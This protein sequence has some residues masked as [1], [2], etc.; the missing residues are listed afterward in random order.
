MDINLMWRRIWVC[1]CLHI[2]ISVWHTQLDI[3]LHTYT[4]RLICINIYIYIHT[5][6]CTSNE[7]TAMWF[8]PF[9]CYGSGVMKP[10]GW[11]KDVASA[12][13]NLHFHHRLS[14]EVIAACSAS[15]ACRQVASPDAISIVR[16]TFT[17][18]GACH[19]TD[20]HIRTPGA[21]CPFPPMAILQ[22]FNGWKP[23]HTCQ[24]RYPS[25]WL[26][27]WWSPLQYCTIIL[28]CPHSKLWL[29]CLEYG[30][31]AWCNQCNVKFV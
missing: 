9:L 27:M 4:H 19:A 24:Q 7:R 21:H 26:F 15:S 5:Y 28:E 23:Y 10:D 8:P 31:L 20:C 14:Q 17:L 12:N 22:T 25:S 1:T 29:V 13:S 30:L 18:M 3:F 11:R 2:C 16:S 6:I